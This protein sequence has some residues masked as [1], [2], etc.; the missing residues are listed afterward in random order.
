MARPRKHPRRTLSEQIQIPKSLRSDT[1]SPKSPAPER[2]HQALSDRIQHLKDENAGLKDDNAALQFRMEQEAQ[3]HTF[4]LE[5]LLR[6]E[7]QM[8][9]LMKRVDRA[10]GDVAAAKVDATTAKKDAAS[11]KAELTDI[12]KDLAKRLKR[13]VGK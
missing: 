1:L 4:A 5:Q 12:R 10:E 8:D 2:V 3:G 9:N 13:G 7:A 6:L 11:A